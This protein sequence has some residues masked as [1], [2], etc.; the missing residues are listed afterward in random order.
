M[1]ENKCREAQ[2]SDERE[3]R[4]RTVVEFLTVNEMCRA[5]KVSRNTF[6]KLLRA[7]IIPPPLFDRERCQRWSYE[8][9]QNLQT[10]I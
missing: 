7:G 8:D 2:D 5:L 3:Q 10:R 6:K 1:G 9:L 4:K